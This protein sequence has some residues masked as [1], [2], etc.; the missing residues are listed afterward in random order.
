M[1]EDKLQTAFYRANMRRYQIITPNTY[2]SWSCH[3]MDILC[4]RKSGYID[5]I[6]IKISKSDFLADFKKT[7]HI[8]TNTFVWP[9]VKTPKHEAMQQG[10]LRCNRFSFLIPESL[11]DK[12]DIPEYAGLYV[13]SEDLFRP[14]VREIKKPKLFHKNKITQR[15]LISLGEK[16]AYRYWAYK[17]EA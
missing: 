11:I 14:Y 5:E 3:E 13:A 7:V 16:M 1:T 9:R 10:L 2:L 8:K 12:I 6:E 15:E 4:V 17:C